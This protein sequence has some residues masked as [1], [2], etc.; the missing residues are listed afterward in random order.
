MQNLLRA[1]LTT[2]SFLLL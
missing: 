1:N 2:D